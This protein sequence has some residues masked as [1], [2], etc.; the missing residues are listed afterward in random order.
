MSGP[1]SARY[2]TVAMILHWLIALAIITL[3]AVGKYMVDLPNDDPDKFTLYQLHKSTGLTVLALTLVRIL[4]RLSHTVP[5]LPLAM[6][7]WQRFAATATHYVFYFMMLAIPLAGWA[8]VSSSSSGIPTIW[9]GL[10]EVPHLPG[11]QEAATRKDL[12]EQ[13]KAAHEILGNLTILLLLL[14][15]GAALKHHFWD[16]DDILSRMLPFSR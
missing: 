6:P 11:L 7:A 5:A 9:F 2:N 1:H 3:L 4:W 13:A 15:V 10:F 8:A 16:R 14:H 12:H